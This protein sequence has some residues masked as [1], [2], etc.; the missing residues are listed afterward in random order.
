MR[1]FDRDMNTTTF[2]LGILFICGCL[3][4]ALQGCGGE[5]SLPP[6]CVTPD[7]ASN[8][9]YIVNG[10]PS[11]DFRGTVSVEGPDGR[12]SGT[13]VG[14]STVLTAAHCEGL[15][16]VCLGGIGVACV[17]VTEDIVYPGW[18][19]WPEVDDLRVLHIDAPDI[20]HLVVPIDDGAEGV[21]CTLV[22]QGYGYGSGGELHEREVE[23]VF[24]GLEHIATGESVCNGDSGGPLYRVSPDG[25]YT[26][27]GV[28]SFGLNEPYECTG[29]SVG[30]VDLTQSDYRE[31]VEENI[32]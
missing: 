25:S 21:E 23:Q 4:L 15:T 9:Q 27:V 1:D 17:A 29:G 2:W 8:S 24:R 12:C 10:T 26:L 6:L 30:F 32:R 3:T 19:V 18:T 7:V 16:R 28:T 5:A 11:E 14:P 31:W 13:I 22:T 20:A